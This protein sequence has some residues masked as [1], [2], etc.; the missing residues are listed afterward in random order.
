MKTTLRKLIDEH[1]EAF[2]EVMEKLNN[3]SFEDVLKDGVTAEEL[4]GKTPQEIFEVIDSEKMAL[5][6][7]EGDGKSAS[8]KV[9]GVSAGGV[10]IGV[11]LTA[12]AVVGVAQS[13]PGELLQLG[14][15]IGGVLGTVGALRGIMNY[16]DNKA[17]E[18]EEKS[19]GKEAPAEEEGKKNPE[20][21]T[22]KTGPSG[23]KY[24]EAPSGKKVY[25]KKK[26]V[27]GRARKSAIAQQVREEEIARRM[28]D[29]SAAVE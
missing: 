2:R 18:K 21:H 3:I 24:Y 7:G 4:E 5:A 17:R 22:L 12:M 1:P 20:G 6:L 14:G 25:V 26:A 19:K 29:F 28:L 27:S 13:T 9:A 11:F 10:I 8:M 15:A 23:A 16:S